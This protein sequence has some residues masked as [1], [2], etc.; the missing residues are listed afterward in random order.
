LLDAVGGGG[1]EAG[2]GGR[3]TPRVVLTELRVEPHLAIGHMAAGHVRTL[4]GGKD[5]PHSR[6]AV[7]A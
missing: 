5:R 3:G 4:L 2:L 7:I 6:P 1:T